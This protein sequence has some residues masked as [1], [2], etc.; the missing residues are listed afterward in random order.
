MITKELEVYKLS[1]QLVLDVY[2][3]TESFPKSETYGL[4]SQTRRAAVSIPTNL[5][6]GGG[7]ASPG[8]LRQY[9][10]IARGS[11]AELATLLEIGEKLGYL[12]EP[13]SLEAR[14]TV[15]GKMLS[16]LAKTLQAGSSTT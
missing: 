13:A 9:V 7:R 3:A 5:A 11:C 12:T 14:T 1:V 8:E 16:A 4:T 15:I 10:T 6:E 2:R